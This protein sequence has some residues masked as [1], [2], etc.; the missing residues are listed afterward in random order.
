MRLTGNLNGVQSFPLPQWLWH[1]DDDHHLLPAQARPASTHEW[2][3]REILLAGPIYIRISIIL[4]SF[5]FSYWIRTLMKSE[6]HRIQPLNWQDL[7]LCS[8]WWWSEAELNSGLVAARLINLYFSTFII[9]SAS[10]P[11]SSAAYRGLMSITAQTEQLTTLSC[12]VFA[13]VGGWQAVCG[14]WWWFQGEGR[15]RGWRT[16][17]MFEW[18]GKWWLIFFSG[19]Y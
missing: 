10:P 16:V 9:P 5:F 1:A 19:V 2:P 7:G 3:M 6:A 8:G 17:A 18:E 14:L 11:S 15:W 12:S 4:F 13:S